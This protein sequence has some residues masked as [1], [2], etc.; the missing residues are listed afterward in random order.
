MTWTLAVWGRLGCGVAGGR[1]EAARRIGGR[2]A[3]PRQE[4]PPCPCRPACCWV[5]RSPPWPRPAPPTG[6]AF[7][8]PVTSGTGSMATKP[9]MGGWASMTQSS[10]DAASAS[11]PRASA[12]VRSGPVR[13]SKGHLVPGGAARLWRRIDLADGQRRRA[14][15]SQPLGLRCLRHR[16]SASPPLAEP[17]ALG[18]DPPGGTVGSIA[19]DRLGRS[20]ARR[21]GTFETPPPRARPAPAPEA[22]GPGAA[23]GP[24]GP[25]PSRPP[26]RPR[27]AARTG[28]FA[29]RTMAGGPGGR[30][31][32]RAG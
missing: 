16:S 19:L 15:P 21:A 23:D 18:A 5:G 12:A 22:D 31:G 30:S 24:A 25:P 8:R 3:R 20:W 6:R 9:S 4:A 27:S 28:S 7:A 29:A 10:A 32:G 11:A 17:G 26:R 2:L 1:T 13:S 14:A